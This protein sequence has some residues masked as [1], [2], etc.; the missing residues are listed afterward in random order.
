PER[1]Q[2]QRRASALVK[3]SRLIPVESVPVCT[4]GFVTGSISARVAR[5]L[6]WNEGSNAQ[7]R[8]RSW[9]LIPAAVAALACVCVTYGPALALTHEVTEWLVR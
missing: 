6:A 1:R 8:N 5:L 4:V 2:G 3:L 9:Y 7:P